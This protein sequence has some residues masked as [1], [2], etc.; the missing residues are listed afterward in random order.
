MLARRLRIQYASDL[1]LEFAENFVAPTILKPIA[2]VLALA[3]DVGRPDK[4]TYRDF[5]Q[6][7]SANWDSVFIVAGNHEF[8]NSSRIQ[9]KQSNIQ[10]V[11]Q[12]A[13]AIEQ[14]V[15]EFPNVHFLNRRRV[16]Y[17]GIAF[18][19]CTLWTDTSANFDLA[20]AS[21]NDYAVI[22]TDGRTPLTPQETTAWHY[23]DRT[24]LADAIATCASTCTP[25]VVL[26][27]HLPSSAFIASKFQGHP[28]NMCFA[29]R[30]DA[31]IKPPVRA[32]IAGHTHAAVNRH[33]TIEGGMEVIHGVVNP[34]GYPGES[35]TGYSREIF[36]D[37]PTEPV[38]E[39]ILESRDPLLVAAADTDEIEFK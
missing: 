16:D 9:F 19:G 31:L 13:A 3:G 6:Y 32:W 7:C 8:Y 5:L 11:T 21:M 35:Q 27:H 26:T 30:C 14:T 33:W 36:V 2:P 39:A 10:T 12:R 15:A 38:H 20:A 25:A 29:A 37:I 34:R 1:H 4:R 18:L 23:T 24:W 28:L 22:T 17:R